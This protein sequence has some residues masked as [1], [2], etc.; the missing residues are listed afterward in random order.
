MRE[1]SGSKARREQKGLWGRTKPRS[2]VEGGSRPGD[3]G[4][5]LVIL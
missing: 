4:L 2:R 3:G 1:G 5:V